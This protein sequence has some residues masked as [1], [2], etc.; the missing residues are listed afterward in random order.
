MKIKDKFWLL[1]N[2]RAPKKYQWYVG[3]AVAWMSTGFITGVAFL[4]L[5]N[6]YVGEALIGL[7]IA[8][9][10]ALFCFWLDKRQGYTDLVYKHN[11]DRWEERM[12]KIDKERPLP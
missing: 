5:V 4:V 8:A 11:L 9:F 10:L 6:G 2:K 7:G 12:E 1:F 3:G